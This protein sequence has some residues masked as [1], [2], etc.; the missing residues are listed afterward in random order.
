MTGGIFGDLATNKKARLCG[1]L[2]G[3]NFTYW[4]CAA[5]WALAVLLAG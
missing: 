2:S 4:V 3:R 1:E 5:L